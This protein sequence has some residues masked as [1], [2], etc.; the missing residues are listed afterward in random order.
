[1]KPNMKYKDNRWRCS[2]RDSH[3]IGVG[4]TMRSAYY[5]WKVNNRKWGKL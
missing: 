3:I 5:K 4:P 2:S 1:M